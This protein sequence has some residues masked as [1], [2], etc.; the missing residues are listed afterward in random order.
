MTN[1]PSAASRNERSAISLLQ[2]FVGSKD[3]RE[4]TTQD[5]EAWARTLKVSRG[6]LRTYLSC[7]NKYFARLGLLV[8]PWV[9]LPRKL[10]RLMGRILSR[11]EVEALLHG[12]DVRRHSGLRNRALLEFLYATG[13]RASEVRRLRLDDVDLA[14][15]TATVRNGKGAKD[16]VVPLTASSIAW[17]EKY[18]EVRC[19]NDILF[20][21]RW[22]KPFSEVGFQQILRKL[23]VTCHT[24]RRTMATHLLENGASPAD[25]A[26]ILGHVNLETLS[27]YARVASKEVKA[28]HA[29]FHPREKDDA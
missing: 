8:T 26:A 18:L 5:V 7:A 4:V 1:W 14:A 24:I 25:V 22:G 29:R 28:A 13:L 2:R 6:T 23:G 20:L 16:R 21:S 27:R 19:A 11:P 15:G 9:E 3:V 17:L 10:R 12:C